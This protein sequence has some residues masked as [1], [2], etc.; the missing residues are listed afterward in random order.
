M[1]SDRYL[2]RVHALIPVL[3]ARP[4]YAEQLRHRPDETFKDFQEA[5]IFRAL[6]PQRY[7]GYELDP[8]TFFQAVM[9]IGTVCGS[10]AWVLTILG[11][12]NWHLDLFHPQA[13]EDVWHEDTDFQTSP[14]LSPTGIVERVAGGF[15]LSGR[16]SFSSG[17][18]VCHW[19][20]LGGLVPA[21]HQD[22]ALDMRPPL[23]SDAAMGGVSAYALP[24][25]D[26]FI[27]SLDRK[28]PY[29]SLHH[30]LAV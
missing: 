19:V 10:S 13:Q 16:W 5:G 20:V 2:E 11:A 26:V 23:G 8:N 17:C 6:Q 7:E 30:D 4:A 27:K 15:R 3:R 1:M 28:D 18:D 25:L 9:E 24:I 22:A 12:H 21:E 14:S 29:D